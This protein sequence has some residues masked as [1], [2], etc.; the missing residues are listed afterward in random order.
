M[1]QKC[2]QNTPNQRLKRTQEATTTKRS[3]QQYRKL[4]AQERLEA[5][6]R[7]E[8]NFSA[9]FLIEHVTRN[10]KK[11][12]LRSRQMSK[13]HTFIS[14]NHK[15]LQAVLHTYLPLYY[16]SRVFSFSQISA[17]TPSKFRHLTGNTKLQYQFLNSVLGFL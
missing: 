12:I 3:F 13:R 2:D 14:V 7:H 17:L 6:N 4:H 16:L 11:C 8:L 15:T 9:Y 1:R 5:E 10:R